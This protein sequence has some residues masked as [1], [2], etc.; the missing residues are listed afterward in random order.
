MQSFRLLLPERIR[1]SLDTLHKAGFEAYVVGGCVRDTLLGLT[2]HDWDIA[3]SA[4]PD[5]I[6]EIFKNYRQIDA[7]L[8]H[9]TVMVR[10]GGETIEIT[11]FRVD[12]HYSDGRRPDSVTFTPNLA[13]DL[14]RRDFTVNACAA[15]EDGLIDPFGG[16]RDAQNRLIRCVGEPQ[17]RFEEDALRIL[18]G[19]RFSSVLDFEVDEKTK[20]AMYTCM[21]L[22][23]N[24]SQERV[25]EELRKTLLG[26]A[27]KRT[28]L[29]YHAF[30]AFL[31]PEIEPT[32]H[33]E[34]HNT[35]HCFD[36]YT[37]TASAVGA[38]EQDI[39]IRTALLFHDIAKPRC[40]T[41]T[42]DI[43]HFHGHQRLSADMTEA[44]L[45]RMKFPAAEIRSITQLIE[46]HDTIFDP[47][48]RCVKRLLNR[49]GEMQLRRLLKIKR[50]DILAQ[51]PE[52]YDRLNALDAMES[53][54]EEILSSQDCVTL[55]ELALNGTDL[56]EAGVPKG[57]MV[58]LLLDRLLGLVLDGRAENTRAAL[59]Q[60]LDWLMNTCSD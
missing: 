38:A 15:T 20:E 46:H 41:M 28:L 24:V 47:T 11:T 30:I 2:P 55:K 37:H 21:P 5:R 58:G 49:L 59:L 52:Y 25:T 8:K 17:R 22:L 31:I 10:I 54:L 23:R 48:E 32:F 40:Y 60:E 26:H 35:H 33:F 29:E 18:R 4:P 13:E 39:L 34:Q 12:G 7:G 44:I 9:G 6:Q 19:I 53:L 3:T 45:K 16:Q 57:K 50:A 1:L 43:G 51:S 42:D 56:I 14:A 36:V 27:V